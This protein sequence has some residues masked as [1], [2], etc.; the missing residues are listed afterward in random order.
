MR[1]KMNGI[2]L[3]IMENETMGKTRWKQALPGE[4]SVLSSYINQPLESGKLNCE[5]AKGKRFKNTGKEARS[6]KIP[7]WWGK[8]TKRHLA[9]KPWYIMTPITL[10][11]EFL[12]IL[13]KIWTSNIKPTPWFQPRHQQHKIGK[14]R[15]KR[16]PRIRLN[17]FLQFIGPSYL[18]QTW[19]K[20][21]LEPWLLK[22]NFATTT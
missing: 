22:K 12:L 5:T 17:G 19:I 15:H 16:G 2:N 10:V 3:P 13:K 7:C 11:T 1:G 4:E 20:L 21:L 18:Y 8:L 6:T 14:I 9:P